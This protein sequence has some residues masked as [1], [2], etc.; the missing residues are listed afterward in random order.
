MQQT[1]AIDSVA[2]ACAYG[3]FDKLRA[4]VEADPSCIN[5]PDEQ[6][7]F[8]LQVG[9]VGRLRCDACN[10]YDFLLRCYACCER[11]STSWRA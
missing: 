9:N 3:D 6:G 7:Y 2:K 5:L 11:R 1:E 4:F 8:P 10:G